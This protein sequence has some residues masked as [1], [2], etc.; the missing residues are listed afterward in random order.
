MPPC[1]VCNAHVQMA[2]RERPGSA[3]PPMPTPPVSRFWGPHWAGKHG[4]NKLPFILPGMS[5]DISRLA[6]TTRTAQFRT[7]RYFTPYRICSPAARVRCDMRHLPRPSSP[8]DKFEVPARSPIFQQMVH[9]LGPS[10]L[11]HPRSLFCQ[12]LLTPCQVVFIR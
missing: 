1:F 2:P 4:P 12:S 8:H 11:S 10:A 6:Q 9:V 5:M 3:I 7:L